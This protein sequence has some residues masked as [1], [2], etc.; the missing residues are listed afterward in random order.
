MFQPGAAPDLK[1]TLLIDVADR[2][3]VKRV[4]RRDVAARGNLRRDPGNAATRSPVRH[5]LPVAAEVIS[6]IVNLDGLGLTVEEDST[7][8]AQSADVG[9]LLRQ[10]L[11]IDPGKYKRI[12]NVGLC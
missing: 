3:I 8:R 4:T 12:A 7:V 10:R 5:R 6:D 2:E 11:A 1:Q 9:H